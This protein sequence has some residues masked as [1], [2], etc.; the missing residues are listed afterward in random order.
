V[1]ISFTVNDL[2]KRELR[3]LREQPAG[4]HKSGRH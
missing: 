4:D 2:V 3:H 1:G